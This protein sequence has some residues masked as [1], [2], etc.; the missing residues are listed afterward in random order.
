MLIEQPSNEDGAAEGAFVFDATIGR[1]EGELE[2]EEVESLTR[3]LSVSEGLT[4]NDRA[5]VVYGYGSQTSAL[6]NELGRAEGA[7]CR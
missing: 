1:L 6:Y 4:N 7:E 2:L 5:C 3:R